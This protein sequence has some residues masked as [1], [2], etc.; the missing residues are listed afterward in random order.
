LAARGELG[1]AFWYMAITTTV[2]IMAFLGYVLGKEYGKE[3]IGALLGT[4]LGTFLVWFDILRAEKLI[5]KK[6]TKR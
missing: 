5:L 1:R 4:L 2:P 6:K 3:M